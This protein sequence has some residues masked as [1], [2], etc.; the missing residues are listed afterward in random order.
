VDFEGDG[1]SMTRKATLT[2]MVERTVSEILKGV[3]TSIPGHVLEFDPGSQ[4]AKLQVGV[5]FVDVSGESFSI[6]PI[7]NVYVHFSGGDYALEHQI[8]PGNEGLIVISQRC[9]DAWKEQGG[10]ATQPILRKLDMQDALFIPGFRSKP[11]KLTNFQNNG[12]RLRNKDADKFIWLKN[13][14][15]AEITVDTLYVNANIVHQGN[16]NQT[17]DITLTGDID[18]TGN[19][20]IIGTLQATNVY[21]TTSMTINGVEVKDHNHGPGTYLDGGSNNVTGNSGNLS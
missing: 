20:T 17:G 9:I 8:D 2:E 13:D 21:A 19:N 1:D 11:N 5:E 4:I 3:G 6:A 16:T 10:V 18:Q 14:G 7:V 12:I 15:T